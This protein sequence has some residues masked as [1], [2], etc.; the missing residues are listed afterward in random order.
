MH[1][2][3]ANF[4][5][6]DIKRSIPHVV[7][8]LKPSQRKV[9][10]ACLKKNLTSDMKV[11]QLSGYVAEQTQ[12]H[13]GEQSLQ[14]TIIGLAQNFTGSNNLNLLEPSG[15][16]GTRLMG[17]KDAASPRY[18]FTRL[19]S[20]TRAI[21]DSRDDPILE[22]EIEDGDKVEPKFYVPVLPMVLVNGAEGIGTGFS[23]NIPP[24]NPVDIKEN[25]MRMM[26][27]E[28]PVSMKPYW[29]GFTGEVERLNQALLGTRQDIQKIRDQV[30]AAMGAA[31]AGLFEAHLLVLEDSTLLNEVLRKIRTERASVDFEIPG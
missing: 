18:I 23:C 7:D 5:A 16:F 27:G 29:R 4:S 15:Q 30:S 22:Y 1:R 9:I 28:A 25:L 13:H 12:Y 26:R 11:A 17:G 19:N 21:F 2:D 20:Q 6:E 10:Y 8:G 24:Y 31:E 14:G 3:L